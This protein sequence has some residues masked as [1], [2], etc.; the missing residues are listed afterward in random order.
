M[1]SIACL[2]V[3]VG[4]LAA[5][6]SFGFLTSFGVFQIYY[7]ELLGTSDSNVSWI[8][9]TPI[10]VVSVV[11]I[12]S[13]RLVDTGHFRVA[14]IVGACL[15]VVGVFCASAAKG[16]WTVFITQAIIMGLGNGLA[17]TPCIW[18]VATHFERR[19]MLAIAISSTGVPVGALMFIGV[20]KEL[21]PSHGI[22]PYLRVIGYILIATNVFI[23]AAARPFE[24]SEK[25]LNNGLVDF[26]AFKRLDFALF[27]AGA[28][29]N[30]L[31]S[32]FVPFYIPSFDKDALH[33]STSSHLNALLLFNAFGIAGCILMPWFADQILGPLPA[34]TICILFNA[35]ATF[36]WLI[37]DSEGPLWVFAAYYGFFW[38]AKRALFISASASVILKRNGLGARMAVC[39]VVTSVP[40]LVA[41]PIGG[42][43]IEG[44]GGEYAVAQLY[45]GTMYVIAAG[46]VGAA[47]FVQDMKRA[48]NDRQKI[49][50]RRFLMRTFSREG[51]SRD[52]SPDLRRTTSA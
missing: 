9:S 52:G 12:I 5:I 49:G 51:G 35:S 7:P 36:S 30:F 23:I 14:V 26:A 19:K 37:V 45:A 32:Y 38:H 22:G 47:W 44:F 15:Q 4:F 50:V 33:Q 43:I 34:F 17:Y 31:S 18:V 46:L 29:F 39:T 3:F 8:G 25:S 24:A 10:F 16:Y 48:A 1:R 13:G 6:N 41:A 40:M 21:I 20:S 28:C 11:S 42:A 27:V 2:Q